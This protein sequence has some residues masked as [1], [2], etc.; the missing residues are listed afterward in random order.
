LHYVN[1]RHFNIHYKLYICFQDTNYNSGPETL[2]MNDLSSNG[3]H[4]GSHRQTPNFFSPYS[5]IQHNPTNTLSS[6]K[7]SDDHVLSTSFEWETDQ[8]VLNIPVT[9]AELSSANKYPEKMPKSHSNDNILSSTD[10]KNDSSS[11]ILPAK[12]RNKSVSKS[13][14]F[15][16]C[17][18][19]I[20]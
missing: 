10:H 20:N 5:N 1:N 7:S 16:I 19:V 18:V 17:I 14:I 13:L 9:V 12:R 8:Q 2:P 3:P 11:V 4:N 6:T 15:L